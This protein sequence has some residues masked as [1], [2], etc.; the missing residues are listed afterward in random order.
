MISRS[1]LRAAFLTSAM[2]AVIGFAP[3]A[4]M[5]A[6]EAALVLKGGR[7]HTPAG[8]EQAIAVDARGQ[9]M[10]IGDDAVIAPAIGAATKI[11]ELNGRTVMPGLHDMHVHSLSAGIESRNC[12]FA[13]DATVETVLKAV[14]DCAKTRKEGEW[15]VGGYWNEPALGE[16]PTRAHLDSVAPNNPVVL[17]DTSGHNR[18]VNSN[19]LELAG[20]AKDTPN[21]EDGI[22]ERDANGEP[23]GMLLERAGYLVDRL[24]PAPNNEELAAALKWSLNEMLSY[25]ITSFTEASAG[26]ERGEA[27]L[28]AWAEAADS[29]VLKQRAQ[30]CLNWHPAEAAASDALLAHRN[31]YARDKVSPNCVKLFLDGVPTEGHTAAMLE[32]YADADPKAHDHAGTH[33]M[34]L[35]EQDELTA[36][37]KRF[38]A[39]GLKVKMHAAGDGSVRAALNAIEAARQANGFGGTLHD[40]AHSNLV[41]PEDM[42]RA[43]AMGATFDVSPY[44]FAPAPINESIMTAV[45]PDR[46]NQ[47]WPVRALIDTGALVIPGSDWPVIPS[48]NPWIGIETMVTREV[49][50]GSAE[51]FAAAGAVTLEEA[52]DLYTIRASRGKGLS[53]LTGSLEVGKAADMIVVEKDPFE[54][55]LRDVH[56]TKVDQTI[57]GGEIAYSR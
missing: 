15:I 32:T 52:I 51:K 8:V 4:A 22:I 56:A 13:P 43:K 17:R 2:G 37:V 50:G 26:S 42:A 34:L 53:N 24:V 48:V 47:S 55:P 35:I 10:A 9:I 19:A 6:E 45:G 20:Y 33:G 14:A 23:T 31:R 11:I 21:P 18:W 30:L 25:G 36:L 29:G 57:I 7:V 27:E 1:R 5:A 12:N 49:E 28:A 46:A 38:D 41:K 44:L 54:V 16:K 39:M 3:L 40:V